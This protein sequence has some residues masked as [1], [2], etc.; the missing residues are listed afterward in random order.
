MI[1]VKLMGGLGNQMFQYAA[2][3]ALAERHNTELM[4]DLTWY[5]LELGKDITP[6]KYELDCF[7]LDKGTPKY[8]RTIAQRLKDICN[9]YHHYTEPFFSYNPSFAEL[10]S[11]TDLTGYFQ[12]EKYFAEQAGFIRDAFEWAKPTQGKNLQLLQAIKHDDRSVSVHVRRGDYAQ[13][14]K[15]NDFHG[16]SPIEY[17]RAA[18]AEIK[19][20]VKKP[21][22]YVFSDEPAWCKKHLKFDIPTTYV[23]HNVEGSEDM[24]LM[25]E[26]RHNIIANSSFSWWG[27]WL[28]A[29]PDKRVI[30]PKHWFSHK[31]TDTSDVIP[32][33]WKQ[34]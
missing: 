29:S 1:R 31:E 11:R 30:A 4:L 10:P 2:G 34:I 21:H 13:H 17:Y 22:L 7:V 14:K 27:A 23:S 8:E 33:A 25:K 32:Q 19:K 26:C 24:R 9:P 16:V 12:S 15:T 3:R 20:T 5:D 28:N 6:R 18:V